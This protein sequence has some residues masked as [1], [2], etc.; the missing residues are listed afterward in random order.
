MTAV[1]CLG[2]LQQKNPNL[3][4]QHYGYYILA[5]KM[6]KD[7]NLGAIVNARLIENKIEQWKRGPDIQPILSSHVVGSFYRELQMTFSYRH[8]TQYLVEVIEVE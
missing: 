2:W 8:V 5:E 6:D 3:L 1:R 7:N 4:G